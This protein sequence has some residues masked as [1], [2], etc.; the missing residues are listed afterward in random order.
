M[1]QLWAKSVGAV[2]VRA[3][4]FSLVQ[5]GCLRFGVLSR[6]GPAAAV[7]GLGVLGVGC[8]RVYMYLYIHREG[9]NRNVRARFARTL[10]SRLPYG[11]A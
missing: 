3:L 10:P 9:E 6:C 5:Q 4:P 7:V 11:V 1:A 2:R 8:V